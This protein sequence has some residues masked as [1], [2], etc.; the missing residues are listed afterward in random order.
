MREG[1]LF[2][3]CNF[4]IP[5]FVDL[6]LYW[7]EFAWHCCSMCSG[8]LLEHSDSLSNQGILGGVSLFSSYLLVS[9]LTARSPRYACFLFIVVQLNPD[10]HDSLVSISSKDLVAS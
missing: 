10:D 5:Y 4:M 9:I 8:W 6:G 3:F 2:Y 1:R 7:V